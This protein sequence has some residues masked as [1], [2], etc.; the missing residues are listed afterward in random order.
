MAPPRFRHT[1]RVEVVHF[2]QSTTLLLQQQHDGPEGVKIV[3][4]IIAREVSMRVVQ[5]GSWQVDVHRSFTTRVLSITDLKGA[6]S[7]VRIIHTTAPV[8]G[9]KSLWYAIKCTQYTTPCDYEGLPAAIAAVEAIHN[10]PQACR[11]LEHAIID[12]EGLTVL[13]M[14]R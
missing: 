14:E 1:V 4:E 9:Q 7:D 3:D 5:S 10:D 6:N 13:T 12:A 11:E 2:D 8:P